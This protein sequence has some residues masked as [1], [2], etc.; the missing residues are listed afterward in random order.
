MTLGRAPA[1]RPA[2]GA[3][4]LGL[5]LSLGSSGCSFGWVKPPPRHEDWP[6]PVLPDSSEG[7]CTVSLGP[8][9]L[10]TLAFGIL[11]TLGYIER[12]AITYEFRPNVDMMGNLRPTRFGRAHF[13]PPSEAAT[14]EPDYLARGIAAG[15]AIGAL[16]AAVSAVYGYV[17]YSRCKRYHALF[18]PPLE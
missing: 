11:G 2:P 16:A 13:T 17:N 15:F 1:R 3:L 12:D 8:P 7:R 18:H 14:P 5:A 10:D 4:A 9:V 6:D